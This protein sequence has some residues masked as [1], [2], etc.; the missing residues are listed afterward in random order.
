MLVE[1]CAHKARCAD[2]L[3]KVTKQRKCMQLIDSALNFRIET[4][5]ADGEALLRQ[6]GTGS[7]S[8]DGLVYVLLERENPL[9]SWFTTMLGASH[10]RAFLQFCL[11]QA[12]H[13]TGTELD[14][15]EK[16]RVPFLLKIL[17]ECL[18]FRW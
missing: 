10:R 15:Q 4:E 11:A 8:P 5:G 2:E 6:D 9:H 7:I 16:I 1:A 17:E 12:G 14:R 18:Q 3:S 13:E